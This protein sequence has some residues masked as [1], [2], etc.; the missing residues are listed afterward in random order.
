MPAFASFVDHGDGKRKFVFAPH[1]GDRGDYE[2]ALTATD[3]GDGGGALLAQSFT[4]RFILS[5]LSASESPL[6][7]PLGD[8]LALVGQRLSFTIDARDL[9]QDALAFAML[10]A[11]AG[12]TL[13][14]QPTYGRALVEWTPSAASLGQS[15]DVRFEVSDNGN[16][17]ATTPNKV[18]QVVRIKVRNANSAPVLAPVGD[19][20]L[21]EG[22]AFRLQLAAIDADGDAL[23]YAVNNRGRPFRYCQWRSQLDTASLQRRRLPGCALLGQRR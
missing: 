4:R 11:P 17:G 15:F 9:D 7:A 18:S 13:T 8:K 23:S 6:L 19:L 10:D 20:T 22:Q 21:L 1:S 14:P 16:K 3:D 2:I 12:M 5:A